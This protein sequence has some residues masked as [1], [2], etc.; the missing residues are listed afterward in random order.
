[1]VF[2]RFL[3]QIKQRSAWLC[4]WGGGGGDALNPGETGVPRKGEGHGNRAFTWEKEWDEELW[5][6]Y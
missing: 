2:L 3:E 4:L 1:M 5:E 6:G